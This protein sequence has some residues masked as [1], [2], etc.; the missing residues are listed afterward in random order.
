VVDGQAVEDTGADIELLARIA[1]RDTQALAA[2][3]IGTAACSSA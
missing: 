2:C 3:T 1:A